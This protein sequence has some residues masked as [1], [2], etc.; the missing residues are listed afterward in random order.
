MNESFRIRDVGIEVGDLPTG[1]N[2]SITDVQGVEV[3]SV[4]LIRGEGKLK[5]GEG[6]VRTGVTVIL[7]HRGNTFQDK[8]PAACFVLNG[9]GK[10]FGLIQIKELGLLESP[11]AITNTLNVPI[12]AD[13]LIDYMIEQ[14]PK[15]GITMSTVNTIVGECNDAFLNDIQ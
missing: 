1:K 13:A 10:T 5:P 12:V 7:P 6:P 3:G 8:I 11:I 15:I 4:T 9:Y 14:N 2:N